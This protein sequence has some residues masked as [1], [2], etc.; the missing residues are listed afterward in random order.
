MAVGDLGQVRGIRFRCVPGRRDHVAV[1]VG[2]QD[3]F[4]HHVKS[5]VQGFARDLAQQGDVGAA[6]GV[7]FPEHVPA[8]HVLAHDRDTAAVVISQPQAGVLSAGRSC[9]EYT[10]VCVTRS[11]G[12]ADHPVSLYSSPFWIFAMA[13][14]V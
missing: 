5:G 8:D 7:V 11:A 12:H 6:R 10:T 13:W 14:R 2:I 9:R 3:A 4:E 1:A